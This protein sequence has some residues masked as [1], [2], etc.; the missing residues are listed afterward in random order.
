MNKSALKKIIL[1]ELIKE[2]YYTPVQEGRLVGKGV[3]KG[4]IQDLEDLDRTLGLFDIQSLERFP[5]VKGELM[6]LALAVSD[7]LK[8]MKDHTRTFRE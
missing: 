7:K 3:A 6:Q 1:E 8:Y 4:L 5:D 2:S